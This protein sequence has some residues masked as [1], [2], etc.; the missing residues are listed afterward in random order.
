M[1]EPTVRVLLTGATGLIGSAVRARLLARGHEVVAVAR[2]AGPA[3]AQAGTRWIAVDMRRATVPE[4]W[5]PH[6]AGIDAAVNCA[7]V[8]QDGWADSTAAVH[9]A[10]PAALFAALER[11]GVLRVVQI[12]AIG[13][14]RPAATAFAHSKAVGDAA[15]MARDLDWVIL[16]PSLVVARAAYGGSALLRG[17]AA[18]PVLPRIAGAGPLQ[19][20]QLDDLVETV[21][22]FLRPAAPARLTLEVCGPEPLPLEA[23]L[24]TYRQWMG[25]R[26]APSLAVPEWAMQALSR[27][28]DALG[29]LGWRSP[30]RSTARRE[31]ARGSTGDPRPWT[32]ITGIRPASLAQALAATPLAVQD[33]WFA[34]LYFLKPLVL[35]ILSLYWLLTGLVALGP[36]WHA[37]LALLLQ[38]G[39]PAAAAP[40]LAA[41]GAGADILIGLGIALRAT[42]KPAL[43]AGLA[44]CAV[45]LAAGTALAPALWTDPLGPYLKVLP[46][47]ALI[48]AALAIADDR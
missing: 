7:G 11:A 4:A 37:G 19:V 14:D 40:P 3:A 10:G 8:L 24:A 16:R 25:F 29:L 9:V 1:Q 32:E 48:L 39:I 44:L 46:A 34:R 23:I 36:A 30:L 15:L 33:R 22:F 27:C 47:M 6:L 41:A 5:E 28:G 31:L 12:S 20:V 45:Y 26:K 43:R 18:L 2:R 17:L 21:L 35:A 13:I 42:C 38:A